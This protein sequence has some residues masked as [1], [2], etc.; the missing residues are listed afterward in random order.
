MALLT[1]TATGTLI[2]PPKGTTAA[3]YVHASGAEIT[4]CVAAFYETDILPVTGLDPLEFRAQDS[5]SYLALPHMLWQLDGPRGDWITVDDVNV[6]YGGVGPRNALREL[7]QVG[8]TGVAE[9]VAYHRFAD[10]TLAEPKA[11]W[12]L[13]SHHRPHFGLTAPELVDDRLIIRVS[14]GDTVA[15]RRS[16]VPRQWDRAGGPRMPWYIIEAWLDL[17]DAGPADPSLWWAAGGRVARVFLDP[18]AARTQGFTDREPWHRIARPRRGEPTVVVE[19][20]RVQIWVHALA[21]GKD[22]LVS[23]DTTE[24]LTRAQLACE[25]LQKAQSRYAG[26][27]SRLMR[28]LTG[29]RLLPCS[30]IDVSTT[31]DRTLTYIPGS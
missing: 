6:G 21:G 23:E 25:D 14:P 31:G 27:R 11:S 24:A 22:S 4:R 30:W 29:D 13:D 19:Q 8:L 26:R 10:I 18:Q 1:S 5:A 9:A 28:F 12:T 2:R 7:D 15:T 17:M 20:G 3:E 16:L